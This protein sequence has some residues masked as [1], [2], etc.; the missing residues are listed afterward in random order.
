MAG[1]IQAPGTKHYPYVKEVTPLHYA[2][3]GLPK[4]WPLPHTGLRILGQLQN[5]IG[6]VGGF[7]HCPSK[8]NSYC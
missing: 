3:Q 2:S 5:F 1:H 4:V 8:A 6:G 7:W